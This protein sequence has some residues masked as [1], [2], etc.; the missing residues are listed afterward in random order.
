MQKENEKRICQNCKQD[1]I[2]DSG[3]FSFYEKIQVPAPTFCPECRMI[4]RLMW[5]NERSLSKRECGLCK[6]SI[7]SMYSDE[8]TPVYCTECWHGG[9]WDQFQYGRDYDF[10]RPFFEQLRGL[11]TIQPRFYSYKF[12]NFV[13]S[14][15]VNYAKDNKNVYLSFSVIYCEDILYSNV[16]DNS[17]RTMDSLNVDKVDGCYENIYCEGN[18]NTQYAVKSQNCIDSY[19]I[20]DCANCSNCFMSSNLRNQKYVFQNQKLSKEEYV[21]KLEEYQL[22]TYK[23]T[24]K[25]KEE[26]KEMIKNKA[27][28]KYALIYASENVTGDN[29]H[30]ARNLKQVFDTYESENISYASRVLWTKDTMDVSGCGYGELI[31]ESM[32]ATQNTF[33]DSFCYITTEGCRE[34]EYSLVLTNCSNCFGCVGLINAE[35]CIFNK[36]Y[37][38]EEYFNMV[39]KIKKHMNDMPYV[40]AKGRV[41]TYGEFFPYDMCPFGYNEGNAHDF[42]PISKDEALAQGY[43]WKEKE[44]RDYKITMK[45]V[46]LPDS[47]DEVTDAILQEIISCPNNGDQMTQCT[48]AFKITVP[49]LQFYKQKNIPLPRYCPNCRHYDRLT[50]RNPLTLWERKCMCDKIHAHHGATCDIKFQTTYAPERPEKVYCEKCYQAEVY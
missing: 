2:I 21:K 4:R 32:A 40:D 50:Y 37:E 18:Y 17:K 15:F 36:Q 41:F 12:G 35:Y 31:Y 22:S 49:E 14:E 11:F 20:Y 44:K 46:D 16:I 6:K 43:P 45:S 27:F 3:D 28:N 30:N 25:A 19:F 29:D 9:K 13:N 38:K 10:S 42:F 47:I 1:F 34:C 48:S 5:R 24:Q 7:I 26:F 8:A 33:K 39:E 23:G